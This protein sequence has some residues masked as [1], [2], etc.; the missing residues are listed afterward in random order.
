MRT[1]ITGATVVLPSETL[2]ADVLIDGQKIAAIDPAV[3]TEADQ[4]VQAAGLHRIICP[5][6]KD[7]HRT[8][9]QWRC[10]RKKVGGIKPIVCQLDPR[11][12]PV[13]MD[14]FRHQL[15]ARN[16]LIRPQTPFDIR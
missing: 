2:R 11:E 7:R 5:T 13:L 8:R 14:G 12:G 10:A 6:A 4:V 3:H 1:R 15:Q 16:I 9:C